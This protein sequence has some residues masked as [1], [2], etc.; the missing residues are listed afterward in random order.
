MRGGEREGRL[1]GSRS[2][3]DG[4]GGSFVIDGGWWMVVDGGGGRGGT[5]DVQNDS[6]F[7]GPFL[8]VQHRFRRAENTL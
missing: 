7:A 2:Y 3:V 5:F 4:C 8:M 1:T 6:L